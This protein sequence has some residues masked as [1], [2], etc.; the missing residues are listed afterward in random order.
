MS[1]SPENNSPEKLNRIVDGTS[2]EGHIKSDSNIR[3]DGKLKGTIQT[4]GRLVIGPSGFID[5][6]I[7][8][9]NAD[10]EGTFTGKI[11]VNGL[12]TLKHSAKLKGEIIT[13][14]LAIEPGAV[15]SGSCTMSGAHKEPLN[16]QPSMEKKL[17]TI[18]PQTV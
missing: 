6:D 9:E 7:T 14:K 4:R 10:I 11:Q 8:C 16:D 1:K 17:G 2:I 13:A 15:F 3:I 12:L 18:T 5:G